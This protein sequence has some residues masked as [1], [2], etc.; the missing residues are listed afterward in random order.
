MHCYVMQLIQQGAIQA[1]LKLSAQPLPA[2]RDGEALAPQRN[3]LFSLG[4]LAAYPVSRQ[5]F[6]CS[7]F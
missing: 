3:A 4:N 2:D 5:V 7:V 6:H 1:L